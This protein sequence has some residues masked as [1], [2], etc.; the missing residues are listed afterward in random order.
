VT[1]EELVTMCR[2]RGSTFSVEGL[3][4][5]DDLKKSEEPPDD[6]RGES[7]ALV[8]FPDVELAVDELLP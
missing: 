2:E 7:I 4:R 1:A 6:S 3:D 8:S 5:I